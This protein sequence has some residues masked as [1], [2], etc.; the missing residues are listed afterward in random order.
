MKTMSKIIIVTFVVGG[1]I[2]SRTGK[3]DTRNAEKN[4]Q[5]KG[6]H[7]WVKDVSDNSD[8]KLDRKRSHK[9]R[10]KIRKPIKGL[11]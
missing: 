5:S 11:R 10:R 8:V 3:D 9:R 2:F 4:T 7:Y 6:N 1:L